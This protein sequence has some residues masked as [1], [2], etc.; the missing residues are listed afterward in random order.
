MS[1]ADSIINKAVAAQLRAR[2]G[3]LGMNQKD[4]IAASELS[5]STVSRILQTKTE[6]TLTNLTVLA[7]AMGTTADQ[8]LST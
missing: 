4:L 7:T 8:I 1:S 3:L 2:M 6:I 5:T